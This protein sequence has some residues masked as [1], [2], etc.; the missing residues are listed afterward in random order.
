L[1]P[2]LGIVIGEKFGRLLAAAQRRSDQ[3]RPDQR[4]AAQC[5]PDLGHPDLGHPDPGG[6]TD[7]ADGAFSV[8]WRDANP[9]LLRY[10]R[11]IAPEA[12]EDIAADTWVQVVRGLAAFRGDEAAWRA[13][14]F[15]IA[16][17]RA[18]DEGRRR[19]R[20]PVV[21]VPEVADVT[22]PD[23]PDPADLVLEKLST[24]AAVALIA[25]LPRLQAEVILLRVVAGLDTPTVARLV[26]RSP[27]AVR[28]AAHRGLQRLAATL[29]EVGVTHGSV[30]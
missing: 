6:G 23:N 26:G 1:V 12:A 5:H 30:P 27:G 16:R 4:Y 13:W 21:S 8:L 28:V 2:I 18:I 9:A 3:G 20:R 10:L 19:S 15:T 11:V 14:L 24:Q 25:T 29:A 22:S 17:H 7:E